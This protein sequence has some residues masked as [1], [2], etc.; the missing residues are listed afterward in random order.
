[1]IT[2]RAQLTFFVVCLIALRAT[3]VKADDTSL[4]TGSPITIEDQGDSLRI[5]WGGK[6][7]ATYF[8][9]HDK[10]LRPFFANVKSPGG[11]QVTRNFPP[12][13]NDLRDHSDMHPGIWMAFGDVSGEDFWRNKGRVVHQRFTTGPTGGDGRGTFS[14]RK[15][16]QRGD[17]SVV[18]LEDF[19]F[20]IR[21][22]QEGYLL[23]W[24]STFF[25]PKGGEFYF[26]D[27]EEMGLGV[28]VATSITERKGGQITDSHGRQGA[29]DVW[30]QSSAWCDYS[31]S[32]GNDAIGITILCHPG[33]FRESWMHARNYGLI[34]ANPFGRKAMKKGSPSRIVVKAGQP[35]RLRYGIL[36]HGP[37]ADLAKVHE[38]YVGLSG[39]EK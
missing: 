2:L 30:S 26:G 25:A 17:G 22:L 32:V 31:G 27:Q 12:K 23:Q 14:Q 19:R 35:L 37:T 3:A 36:V 11:L 18:C 10:V 34:A 6:D 9:R 24:D 13:K 33:N 20:T 39:E 8:Y 4:V 28:R 21:V 16:Y 5:R 29:K 7:V 15:S 38:Q 1:M